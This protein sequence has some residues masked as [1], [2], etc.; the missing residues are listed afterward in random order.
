MARP[1]DDKIA[2]RIAHPARPEVNHGRQHAVL[3]GQVFYPN[4]SRQL[5]VDEVLGPADQVIVVVPVPG[6]AGHIGQ[7]A[8]AGAVDQQDPD[9][10]VGPFPAGEP[11]EQVEG[12]V[13]E[14]CRSAAGDHVA[15]VYD[16]AVDGEPSGREPAA[17]LFSAEPV[18][19][20]RAA[21][22][23]AGFCDLECAAAAG[24]D[25]GTRRRAITRLRTNPSR[26][27][28]G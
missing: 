27:S 25:D 6:S 12:K 14:G 22:E 17:E 20:G 10:R 16:Q 26:P 5:G 4:R 24:C 13:K 18:C 21:I 19:R 28:P 8:G 15:V 3:P 7:L 9:G 11:L 1:G 23:Q 2:G